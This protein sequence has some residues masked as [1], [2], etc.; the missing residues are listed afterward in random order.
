M[1]M[2]DPNV[3]SFNAARRSLSFLA[4]TYW[5]TFTSSWTTNGSAPAISNGTITA[6]YQ[7]WGPLCFVSLKMVIGSSTTFGTGGWRFSLPIAA[8]NL[9]NECGSAFFEDTGTQFYSGS[10]MV[11]AGEQV[12]HP[13]SNGGAMTSTNPFSW[14]T[15]D[16]LSLSL[17]YHWRNG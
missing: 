10:C 5:K 9:V 14:A 4:P 1:P 15:G 17:A 7:T 2:L 8:L 11:Y 12:V 16:I 3:D 6:Y 13:S